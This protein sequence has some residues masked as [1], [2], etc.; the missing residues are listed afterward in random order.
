MRCLLAIAGWIL[1]SLKNP[2]DLLLQYL[3]QIKLFENQKQPTSVAFN[4]S[5]A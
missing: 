2:P 4:N 1:F 3:S 5:F